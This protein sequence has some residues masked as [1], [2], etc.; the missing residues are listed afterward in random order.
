MARPRN[1]GRKCSFESLEG[2]R[3]LAG[4]VTAFVSHNNLNLEGDT[5]DNGVTIT[6]VA[7]LGN[8]KVTG[9]IVGGSATT[10]NGLPSVM[11][12]G[13]TNNMNVELNNGNDVIN[14]NGVTIFGNTKIE[15]NQG[16]DTVNINTSTIKGSLNVKLGKQHDTMNVVSSTVLGKAVV[17]GNKGNDSV[18]I[19]G[20][21]T[22]KTKVGAL[23]ISLNKGND[24]LKITDTKTYTLTSLNGGK[25]INYLVNGTNNLGFGTTN[26]G[27]GNSFVNLSIKKFVDA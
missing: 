4:N 14:I 7:G 21:A 26:I 9:D 22:N 6:P 17:K 24:Q 18:T 11:L 12:S 13:F 20:S 8:V 15:G 3:M 19:S 23:K 2:R 1:H 27:T 16:L 10:V 25:G 5:F